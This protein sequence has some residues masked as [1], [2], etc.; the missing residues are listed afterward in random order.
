MS[1]L[2]IVAVFFSPA[3]RAWATETWTSVTALDGESTTLPDGTTVGV[4]LTQASRS[5]TYAGSPFNAPE[6]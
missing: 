3:D 4:S 2:A 5:N 1:A 6:L